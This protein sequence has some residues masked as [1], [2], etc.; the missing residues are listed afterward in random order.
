MASQAETISARSWL[1]APGDSERK[2]DKATAGAADIVLLDLED[3]VA[4]GEKPK[5]RSMVTAFLKAH[6]A[7]RARL[8]VR[9]NPLDSEWA[10]EDLAAVM[11][12]RPFGIMQPKTRDGGDVRRLGERLDALEKTAGIPAGQTRVLAIATELESRTAYVYA[13]RNLDFTWEGLPAPSPGDVFFDMEGDPFFDPA[14]GLEFLFG[15]LWRN[16]DGSTTLENGRLA[17]FRNFDEHGKPFP[18][19]NTLLIDSEQLESGEAMSSDF[20]KIADPIAGIVLFLQGAKQFKRQ[21]AAA[22]KTG[23]GY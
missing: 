6:A 3:A 20:K 23:N 13:N 7:Q 1:F 16:D 22:D 4:E 5:A 8:W 2:M 12:G 11:P 18:R 9:I 21:L 10:E 19:P 17:L 14:A 15:V